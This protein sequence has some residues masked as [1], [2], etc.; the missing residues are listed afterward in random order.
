[1]AQRTTR[2][3]EP[4]DDIGA[5]FIRCTEPYEFCLGVSTHDP[6]GHG[7]GPKIAQGMVEALE[8]LAMV[9]PGIPVARRH[10]L[11]MRMVEVKQARWVRP[12]R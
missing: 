10:D 6:D 8:R 3:P 4:K 7:T 9:D 1:M 11:A 5:R 2:T 12:G